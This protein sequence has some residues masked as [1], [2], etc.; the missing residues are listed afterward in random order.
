MNGKII[1]TWEKTLLCVI[2]CCWKA[3]FS[4][5]SV[6]AS[7]IRIIPRT[8]TFISK[9]IYTELNTDTIW[10]DIH[11]YDMCQCGSVCS[12]DAYDSIFVSSVT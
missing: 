10:K 1:W 6:N 4:N 7:D 11:A 8:V 12:F 9:W 5:I 3:K 2:F